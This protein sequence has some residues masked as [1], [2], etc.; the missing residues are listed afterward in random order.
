MTSARLD[1]NTFEVVGTS[2]GCVIHRI[3]DNRAALWVLRSDGRHVAAFETKRA[4][5]VYCQCHPEL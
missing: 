4:A 2:T 5:L 3:G 1:R